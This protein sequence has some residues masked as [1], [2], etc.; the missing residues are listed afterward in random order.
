MENKSLAPSAANIEAYGLWKSFFEYVEGNDDR[1]SA[2]ELVPK[3]SYGDISVI[4]DLGLGLAVPTEGPK[5]GSE[6][7][8]DP[9]KFAFGNICVSCEHK[10]G[11]AK[12][13]TP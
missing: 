10:P 11:L 3:A 2:K 5:T 9:K 7:P 6:N 13:C 4:L 12:D 1:G 8:D